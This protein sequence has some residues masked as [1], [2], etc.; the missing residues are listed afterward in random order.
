MSLS[1]DPGSF[2]DPRGMVYADRD[3][4]RRTVTKAAVD[5][6]EFFRDSGLLAKLTEEGHIVAADL[7][8]SA[9]AAS[10]GPNVRYVLR[11][12]RLAF[13]SYPY[14]WCFSAL[15]QA[16]LLHLDLQ[17]T[18]LEGGMALCDASA[19]NVQFV[20]ARPV[21]IDTLSFARYREGE[22]WAGYRQFCEQFLNPLLLRAL[23]GIP[24]NAWYR[25]SF[26]GVPSGELSR[27]LPWRRCLSRN[28]LVHVLLHG[29]LG[30]S[31]EGQPA[32]EDGALAG[33]GLPRAAYRRIL[34]GLRDWIDRLTPAD[35]RPSYWRDYDRF[36]A[37]SDDETVAKAAFV[38]RFAGAVRPN[39]LW[40]I[41]CNTGDFSLTALE[42]GA[43][44]AVGWDTDQG[45]LE[46]A[47]GRA[48]AAGARFTPLH[49][50]AANPSPA[51][52]WQQAERS[53]WLQRG[54]ADA[55]LALAVVHHL[56]IGRNVPLPAAIDWLMRIAP[57]GVVEFAD[58]DD[59]Q[60]QRMLAQ[61]QDIFPD[62]SLESFLAE[63][64][65]RARIVETARLEPSRRTLVW[66]DARGRG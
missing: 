39:M 49:G 5:D 59:V 19:Y 10:F 2:R 35:R 3:C 64:G 26:E 60:V 63:V 29:A 34:Q 52:G 50:D 9:E 45:A 14:E 12:P 38:G 13:I 11:H 27:L 25:G 21:F 48:A 51:Q 20:G 17:L 33:R 53:G 7:D 6:F 44:Y 55:V 37:Y 42:A 40:D 32:L 1:P 58:K 62:Y 24:H 41:G 18:A 28:V 8:E 31:A 23:V 56:A 43:G 16:A 22:F 65:K 4:I 66:F 47:F 46:A 15:R 30:R 54:P 57:T 36:K 61:R